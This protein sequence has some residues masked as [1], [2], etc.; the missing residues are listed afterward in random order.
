MIFPIFENHTTDT[1]YLFHLKLLS[2]G[3]RVAGGTNVGLCRGGSDAEHCDRS[4]E[5]SQ[6]ETAY[7]DFPFHNSAWLGRVVSVKSSQPE[8]QQSDRK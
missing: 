2:F 3:S 1:R 4:G 8:C 7:F 5:R 6:K